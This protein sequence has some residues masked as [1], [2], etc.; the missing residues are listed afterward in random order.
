[1]LRFLGGSFQMKTF[2]EVHHAMN[3]V[4]TI[5]F[6]TLREFKEFDY[7]ERDRH[8]YYFNISPTRSFIH[9]H[10]CATF[11]TMQNVEAPLVTGKEQRSG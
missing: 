11:T 8:A 9:R 5:S 4:A 10:S 1:M 2:L 6:D 7:L 3:S